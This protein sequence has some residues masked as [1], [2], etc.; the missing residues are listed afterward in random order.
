[1]LAEGLMEPPLAAGALRGETG[2]PDAE[3]EP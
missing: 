3:D 2:E 1:M